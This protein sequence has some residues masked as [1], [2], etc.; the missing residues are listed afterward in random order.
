VDR[1]PAGRLCG[2]A[3][4]GDVRSPREGSLGPRGAFIPENGGVC[5]RERGAHLGAHVYRRFRG[6]MLH[7]S[8]Q[9]AA[10]GAFIDVHGRRDPSCRR[11]ARAAARG[12]SRRPGR[13]R[14]AR[15]PEGRRPLVVSPRVFAA[16]RRA[17][18]PG[19]PYRPRAIRAPSSGTPPAPFPAATSPFGMHERAKRTPASGTRVCALPLCCPRRTCHPCLWVSI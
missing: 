4:S 7:S 8:R 18:S 15:A 2:T 3:A 17:T 13:L 9:G 5:T 12:Q 1:S 11:E 10:R 6:Q 19:I 14:R 16:P